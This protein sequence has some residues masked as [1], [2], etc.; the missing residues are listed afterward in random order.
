MA[1]SNGLLTEAATASTAFNGAGKG[2]A[3][4]RTELRAN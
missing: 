4:A 1:S 2:P 3:T